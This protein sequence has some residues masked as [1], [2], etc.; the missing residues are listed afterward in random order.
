M[1]SLPVAAVALSLLHAADWDRFRGPNG[2]GV[3]SDAAIPAEFGPAKNLLW[4]TA[5]PP[6]HSSPI[7]AGDHIFVTAFEGDKLLTIAL[8]RLTG[9]I[10][11]RREAPRTRKER[12]DPRN[13][14]ASP[15]P[16]SDG[17]S[18]YVFFGDYG[19]ISYGFDGNERWRL[20]LGPFDNMY[21]MGASPVVAG[22][23][24]ILVCDQTKGSFIMA[25]GKD[26]G[27]I[28]WKR[29]RPEAL[30]GHS[31][32]VLFQPKGG[33]LQVIAP[34]SFRMDA[35]SAATGENLWFVHGLASEMKS[36]PVVDGETIY[37]SGYNVPENDPGR[38]VALPDFEEILTKS[39][40][41]HNGRISK[42]ESPDQRTKDFFDFLD[43][44]HDG[45][46]DA[47]EW[48]VYKL[49]LSAENG[50]LALRPG[51][52]RGDLTRTAL[53]WSYRRAIP[54]LPSVL[55]YRGVLYM[56]NDG[57]VLTTLDPA[58]GE[59]FKQ[60]RVRGA[61]DKFYASPVAADGKVIFVSLNGA[62]TVLEAGPAQTVAGFSELDDEVHATPA[63]AGGRIYLRSKSALWCFGLQR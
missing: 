2:A 21:G 29:E 42:A 55:I 6:G 17:R 20:P 14:P 30:S 4:K 52:G 44:D 51:L 39:D 31:T 12:I 53:R 13:S 5:L 32:P 26:D 10:Q 50:L 28:R 22:G 63:I 34:S 35:Y 24:I 57:G 38:Q 60:A 45:Q 3:S 37:I 43:L 19:L 41:D 23:N 49:L 16:A 15:S 9:R 11:W 36:V 54:Q 7:L 58:T 62:I 61:A 56:V 25:A 47:N 27:R 46:L 18:I 48:K 40:A 8:D 59:V 1:N 33:E